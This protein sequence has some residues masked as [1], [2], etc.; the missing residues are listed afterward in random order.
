M[1]AQKGIIL[2]SVAIVFDTDEQMNV[3]AGTSIPAAVDQGCDF[4]NHNMT[5]G[6]SIS[7][8][9]VFSIARLTVGFRTRAL[10]D[11]ADKDGWQPI[12]TLRHESCT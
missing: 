9:N 2:K 8:N 4:A 10:C 12:F 7:F 1:S 6:I 5:L 11:P 3:S